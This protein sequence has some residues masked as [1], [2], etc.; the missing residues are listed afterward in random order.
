[1]TEIMVRH[2]VQDY[3][4]WKNEF[5]NFVD[6]RKSSGEKSYRILH[7]SDNPNDLVLFFEWDSPENARKFFTSQELGTTMKRAGVT[8][9]P[10]IEFVSEV[11]QGKL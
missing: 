4:K 6:T 5:D 3:A 2:N 1:M 11:A 8:G 7:P 10:R 9:E